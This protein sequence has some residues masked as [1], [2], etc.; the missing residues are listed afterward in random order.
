MPDG[1]TYDRIFNMGGGNCYFYSVCQ[2]LEFFGVSIDHVE[3]RTKV[4]LW[5]QNP[6]NAHLMETHLEILHFQLDSIITSNVILRQ[7]EVGLA[8]L[9]G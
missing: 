9:V 4:G 2:G 8:I 7:Q 6:Y 1:H 5:I 3:L